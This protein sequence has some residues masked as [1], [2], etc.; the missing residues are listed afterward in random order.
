MKKIAT[1]LLAGAALLA[2]AASAQ[3][4]GP[5]T[6]ISTVQG[7]S[8]QPDVAA[9]GANVHLV[10][11]EAP[12]G[13][14]EIYYARS[15]NGGGSFAAPVNLSN[16]AGGPARFDQ[17][18]VIA[19]SANGLQ[20]HVFWTDNIDTGSVWYRRSAD[21]G[22][23][24]PT[25]VVELIGGN[26]QYSRPTGALVDSNNCVHLARYDNFTGVS[27]PVAYGNIFHR[28][29]CDGGA[30]WSADAE[31]T[32]IDGEID[33]EQPRLVEINKMLHLMVRRS[34]DGLPQPGWVPF[35]QYLYRGAIPATAPAIS[36]GGA[37]PTTWLRP[38]QKISRGL[39][40]EITNTYGGNLAT[41]ANGALHIA[42]WAEKNGNN[43]HY[44]RGFPNGGG[45][46]PVTDLSGFGGDHLEWDGNIVEKGGFGLA[47]DSGQRVHAVFGENLQTRE[48]FQVGRLFYRCSQNQGVTW[49]PKSQA[50]TAAQAGMVRTA[51][52]AATNKMHV[53]WLD[54]RDA[55]FGAEIYYKYFVPGTCADPASDA[56]NDG[57]PHGVEMLEAR[58]V[59]LKDNDVFGVPRLF[60]MQQYRDFLAREG[61]EP[62]I[63]AWVGLIGGGTTREQVINAFFN[64]V[65]F[66]G[67]VAPVVRLYYATFLRV[68]DYDG[69][70]FN[71]GLVRNGTLTLVQLADFFT[72]SPEF[73]ATYGALNNTQFVTLLYNNVLGRAPDPAGLSGWVSLLEGG[74]SRGQVLVGFS[75][76]TEYKIAKFNEVYVTMMY[77]GMLRRSP[78]PGGYNGWL[79]YLQGGG[80]PLNMITGFYLS[81][82]YHNRFLP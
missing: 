57:M 23:T 25:P 70:I 65:E 72:A 40:D 30:T 48:G 39:P 59:A 66:D 62:G 10:W 67:I 36:Q 7:V 53:V 26:L 17:L 71:V 43:L 16:D 31:V 22:A 76:S 34:G 55:N 82:E 73:Q 19:V 18:P 1:L 28:M 51:Y 32:L 8:Y 54:Y 75:E 41:G 11:T 64:S 24:W 6:R 15:T 68:P 80:T 2:T 58:N 14:G 33:T 78:E 69:L 37:N 52:D 50:T 29:S 35:D 56:D 3:F 79:A 63:Q 5:D 38:A 21:G 45:F 13:T 20:V 44:R 4:F 12:G 49:Q 47:E 9:V 27:G 46:G 61:E 42:Y 77:V 60:A 74:M 81:T